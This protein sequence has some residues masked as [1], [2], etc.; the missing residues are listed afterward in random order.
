MTSDEALLAA[1]R[2]NAYPDGG[3]VPKPSYARTVGKPTFE[4][5]NI[6]GG[7]AVEL[8]FTL[9]SADEYSDDVDELCGLIRELALGQN[10]NYRHVYNTV[11]DNKLSPR[12]FIYTS[13]IALCLLTFCTY[14]SCSLGLSNVASNEDIRHRWN[15]HRRNRKAVKAYRRDAGC[16]GRCGFILWGNV[17]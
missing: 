2:R 10:S 17:N 6:T 13:I 5:S 7:A 8:S 3:L 15:G 11:R 1:Y 14:Q 9:E 12:L 16:C 4:G